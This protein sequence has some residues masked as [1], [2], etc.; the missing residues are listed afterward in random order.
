MP[1]ESN[2]LYLAVAQSL[3]ATIS[4][5]VYG[6]GDR[7]PAHSE[8][9][10]SAKVSR[11]TAR[12]AFLVLELIGAIE[13][14]HGDGTFVR[15]V[16]GGV[17]GVSGSLNA[18]PKELIEARLHIEPVITALAA[19]RI[20]DEELAALTDDLDRAESLVD[21]HTDLP[22][23][24]ALGLRFHAHLAPCSK[25]EILASVVAELVNVEW[26]PLW[27]LVNQQ[28]MG[29]REARH[30]QVDQHRRVLRALASRDARAA[31]EAMTTHLAVLGDV[32]FPHQTAA[33]SR[34][35]ERSTT[36]AR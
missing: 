4:S 9:A 28:A 32:I 24:I 30:S 17:A 14:R 18:L 36:D 31:S 27:T 10:T 1:T 26:H 35:S 7:L 33:P 21:S 22:E 20:T 8:V 11:A 16:D 12:E 13:V 29:S 23:F 19:E 34:G 25:N 3:L 2:R 5:G 6:P 15:R